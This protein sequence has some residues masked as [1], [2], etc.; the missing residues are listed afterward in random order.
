ME[1]SDKQRRAQITG[2]KWKL[3]RKERWNEVGISHLIVCRYEG[4][5]TGLALGDI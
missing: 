3:Q 2:R 5:G 1:G 4:T